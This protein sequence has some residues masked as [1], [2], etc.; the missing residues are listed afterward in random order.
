MIDSNYDLL[1]WTVWAG[2][3][4]WSLLVGGHAV[5]LHLTGRGDR[6]IFDA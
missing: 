2:C 3:S 4:V 1:V 5:Y 6:S